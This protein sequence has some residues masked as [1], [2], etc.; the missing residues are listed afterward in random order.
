MVESIVFLTDE[1]RKCPYLIMK[2]VETVLDDFGRAVM[3]C[4]HEVW[5][6]NGRWSYGLVPDTEGKYWTV[7][8][9]CFWLKGIGEIIKVEK[10]GFKDGR[11]IF[12]HSSVNV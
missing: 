12:N 6:R 1:E 5:V 7:C 9:R 8:N 11:V 2:V 4:G 3:D 10:V